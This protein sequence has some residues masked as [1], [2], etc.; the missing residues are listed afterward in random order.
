MLRASEVP[1]SMTE[2]AQPWVLYHF[3]WSN[4]RAWLLGRGKVLMVCAVCG[5]VEPV[6]FVTPRFGPPSPT[7]AVLDARTRFRMEH[8]HRGK[9]HPRT[10]L[11]PSAN[12]E[13]LRQCASLN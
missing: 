7:Q 1:P 5:T 8:R 4:R 6:V 13:Y 3:L 11:M 9:E 12:P 10:W 2:L